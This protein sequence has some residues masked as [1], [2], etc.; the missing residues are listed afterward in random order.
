MDVCEDIKGDSTLSTEGIIW[1]TVCCYDNFALDVFFSN[2][3]VMPQRNVLIGSICTSI[4][5]R[6]QI[7]YFFKL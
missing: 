6:E 2:N 4:S 1:Y 5:L 3:E 7:I